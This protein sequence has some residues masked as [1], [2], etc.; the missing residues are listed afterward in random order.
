M[1]RTSAS[2]LDPHVQKIVWLRIKSTRRAVKFT[3]FHMA[4]ASR[5]LCLIYLHVYP[6]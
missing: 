4:S 1:G 6:L 3:C 5:V 2:I